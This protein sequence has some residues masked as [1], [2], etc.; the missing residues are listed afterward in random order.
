M[1]DLLTVHP[2]ETTKVLADDTGLR[3]EA[4]RYAQY[5]ASIK[6]AALTGEYLLYIKGA[7]AQKTYETY[8]SKF[9][10]FCEWCDAEN[11]PCLMVER[12]DVLRFVQWLVDRRDLTKRSVGKYKQALLSFYDWLINDKRLV[13]RN[14]VENIPAYGKVVDCAPAPIGSDDRARLPAA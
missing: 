12:E 4:D 6:A 13:W 5:A 8:K 9:K 11:K 7:V 10:Y 14:P 2:D 3:P 1:P